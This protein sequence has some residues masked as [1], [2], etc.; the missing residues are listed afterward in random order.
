MQLTEKLK[1]FIIPSQ[2]NIFL[3]CAVKLCVE[4]RELKLNKQAYPL[5]KPV[6]AAFR[7]FHA[8]QIQAL[9]YRNQIL[10]CF[11]L[12]L[13]KTA[14]LSSSNLVFINKNISYTFYFF[15]FL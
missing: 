2:L 15:S 11:P 8:Y 1:I 5:L 9:A 6:F 7:L 3:Q 4:N 14:F 13:N 12:L 10:N